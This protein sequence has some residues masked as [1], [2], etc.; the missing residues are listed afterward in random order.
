MGEWQ[1]TRLSTHF[2]EEEEVRKHW[3]WFLALGLLLTIMGGMVVQTSFV[4]TVFSVMLFGAVLA[5]AGV[6]QV[7]QAFLARKWSGLFLLLFL[8]I[9]YIISGAFCV[10]RPAEAAITL[11]LWFA[12]FCFI[13]G[14]F[15]M[16]TSL[17]IR[18]QRWGWV[19]FNGLVTSILGSVIYADWPVS[20]LWVIG[21]IIGID[22]VLSGW[23]WILLALTAIS[24]KE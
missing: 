9:L 5:C 12:A 14:I 22:M 15:R 7:I 4:A 16:L 3:G 2:H 17:L 20:G 23:S 10:A 6:V 18:F 13:S 11:T 19:F 8:G 24:R 1:E 21:L